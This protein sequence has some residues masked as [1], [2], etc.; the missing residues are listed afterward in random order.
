MPQLSPPGPAWGDLQLFLVLARKLH[1]GRAAAELGV[2]QPHV[3]RRLR[4]LEE[5]LGLRLVYRTSRTVELTQEGEKLKAE[6]EALATVLDEL[7]AHRNGSA[8]P[9]PSGRR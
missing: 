8:E 5:A 3:S 2:S 6:L 4:R 1:F 7:V 9:S